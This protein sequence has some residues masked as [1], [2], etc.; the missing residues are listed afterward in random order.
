MPQNSGAVQ[1]GQRGNVELKEPSGGSYLSLE[2]KV[3]GKMEEQV[4]VEGAA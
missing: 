2:G 1:T 4:W 3:A